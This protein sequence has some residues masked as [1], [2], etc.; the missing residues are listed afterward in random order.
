MIGVGVVGLGFMGRTHIAAY[1]AL[2]ADCRLVHVCDREAKRWTGELEATGNFGTASGRLFDPRVVRATAEPADL[3]A[4]PEVHLVSICT[5]TDSHVALALAALRAGK[6]VLVEKPVAL[7]AAL[8]RELARVA[9]QAGRLCMPAMCMRFWPGWDWLKD[10]IADGKYGRVLS[11]TFQRLGSAPTWGKG[12]YDD[13]KRSGGALYDLHVHDTDFVV[14]CFGRPDAVRTVGSSLH[15]TTSYRFARGPAHVTAEGAW[16]LAPTAGFRMRYLVNFEHATADFDLARDPQL[17]LHGKLRSEPLPIAKT[18]GYEG[19]ARE[20]VRA[21]LSG[22]TDLR[23]TL[24][25]AATVLDVLAEEHAQVA[26]L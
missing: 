1:Q 2:D 5:P 6:H 9:E 15:M 24:T 10:A 8:V 23:A 22:R 25:Q 7:D 17:L 21:I 13:M 12:F 14:W 11:A 19:Q 26:G 16:D 4:D 18:L 3:F 20:I